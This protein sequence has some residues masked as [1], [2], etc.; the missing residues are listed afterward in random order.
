MI[1]SQALKA[2]LSKVFPESTMLIK[3]IGA[4]LT[5]VSA[6]ISLLMP[7][8]IIIEWKERELWVSNS[9]GFDTRIAELSISIDNGGVPLVFRWEGGPGMLLASTDELAAKLA[10]MLRQP[11]IAS[12]IA[13]VAGLRDPKPEAG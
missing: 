6:E 4:M 2:G 10:D 8:P 9:I 12:L 1:Y 3:L 13:H 11:K 7:N 5:E